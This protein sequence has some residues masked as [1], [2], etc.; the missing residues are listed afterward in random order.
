[1]PEPAPKRWPRTTTSEGITCWTSSSITLV[2]VPLKFMLSLTD[3][4]VQSLRL[5]AAQD[6][7]RRRFA[8]DIA[9]EA[10]KQFIVMQDG[11][12]C[13]SHQNISN[14]QAAFGCWAVV[15]HANHQKACGLLAFERL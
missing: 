9:V 5:P 3:Q 8:C 2:K 11:R 6:F 7:D 12:A 1:M 14:D 13:S 10:R 4:D 15:F